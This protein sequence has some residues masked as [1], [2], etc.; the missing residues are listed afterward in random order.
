MEFSVRSL[1]HYRTLLGITMS[2][3]PSP[4][5]GWRHLNIRHGVISVTGDRRNRRSALSLRIPRPGA[6]D[7]GLPNPL[8]SGFPPCPGSGLDFLDLGFE[9]AA[10]QA[11]TS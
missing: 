2:P 6:G 8:R 11:P 5:H 1:S 7:E 10:I 9:H 4:I 3:D